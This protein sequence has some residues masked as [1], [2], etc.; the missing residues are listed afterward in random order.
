ME[1]KTHI[2][3]RQI[4][5]IVPLV[6]RVVA[7]ELR[8]MDRSLNPGH[9]RLLA[10]LAHHP[11]NLSELAERHSVSLPTMSNS[12]S[13]LVERGWVSRQ[14]DD[15]DRRMIQISLTPDGLALLDRIQCDAEERMAEIIA[16]LSSAECDQMLAGMAILR[17]AFWPGA[18]NTCPEEAP[19][20]DAST[21]G[22][23]WP[24]ITP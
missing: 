12:I 23:G 4:L 13:T 6:M 19:S 8:R 3:A 7:S 1:E 22:P 10:M 14:R 21:T 15:L 24:T 18:G 17:S 11:C 20:P 5:E 16:G 9:F 2:A